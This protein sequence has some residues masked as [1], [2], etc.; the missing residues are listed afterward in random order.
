M[1]NQIKPTLTEAMKPKQHAH[2]LIQ[3]DKK[4]RE[5]VRLIRCPSCLQVKEAAFVASDSGREFCMDCAIKFQKNGTAILSKNKQ[6]SFSQIC[7]INDEGKACFLSREQKRILNMLRSNQMKYRHNLIPLITEKMQKNEAWVR[8]QISYIE[9]YGFHVPNKIE[10]RNAFNKYVRAKVLTLKINGRSSYEDYMGM[11]NAIATETGTS[12]QTVRAMVRGLMKELNIN[13]D[14][15][16][17]REQKLKS[18]NSLEVNNANA[19]I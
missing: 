10:R 13:Q 15:P 8:E 9:D 4:Y 18:R 17:S 2:L 6:S 7:V 19:A 1:E 3:I 14:I 16:L 5:S 12:T 11:A